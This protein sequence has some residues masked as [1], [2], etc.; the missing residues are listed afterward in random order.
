[1]GRSSG[2]AAP[3]TRL[4][5]RW[6]PLAVFPGGLQVRQVLDRPRGAEAA[7]RQAIGRQVVAD[8][9]VR[10]TPQAWK[11]L[12]RGAVDRRLTAVLSQVAQGGA[13]DV[14]AF[15]RDRAMRAADAP[16]RVMRVTAINGQLVDDSD[17]IARMR[18]EILAQPPGLVPDSVTLRRTP[19]PAVLLVSVLRPSTTR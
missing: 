19:S 4:L 13:I 11:S 14:S 10:L 5:R 17:R 12:I 6:E 16:A 2:P 18:A 1:M 15:P 8:I 9:G 3:P 7:T